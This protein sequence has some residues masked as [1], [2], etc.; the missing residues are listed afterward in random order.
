MDKQNYTARELAALFK[1]IRAD[2]AAGKRE[3]AHWYGMEAFQRILD[4]KTKTPATEKAKDNAI[5]R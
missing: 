2:E 5:E 1:E 4:A 3:D